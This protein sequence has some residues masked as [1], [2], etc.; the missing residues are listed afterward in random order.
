MQ[1]VVPLPDWAQKPQRL[2]REQPDIEPREG[3]SSRA[4]LTTSVDDEEGS[5]VVLLDEGSKR[6]LVSRS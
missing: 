5:C 4:G 3:I 6:R 1:V 2:C